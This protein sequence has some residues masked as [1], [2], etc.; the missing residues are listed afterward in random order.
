MYTFYAMVSRL[1]LQVK[2]FIYYYQ[3]K[4]EKNKAKCESK[5][6]HTAIKWTRKQIETVCFHLLSPVYTWEYTGIDAGFMTHMSRVE[7]LL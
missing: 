7:L 6:V 4:R 3:H 1:V 2:Y 5:G